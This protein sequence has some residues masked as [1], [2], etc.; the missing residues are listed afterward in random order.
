MGLMKRINT[1][2]RLLGKE[3]FQ[4]RPALERAI[5][6]GF[7]DRRH[8]EPVKQEVIGDLVVMLGEL[9]REPVHDGNYIVVDFLSK[10][11]ML[12]QL[13]QSNGDWFVYEIGSTQRKR[14]TDFNQRYYRWVRIHPL[15]KD[16][17]NELNRIYNSIPSA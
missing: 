9:V 5:I 11:Q 1:A 12:V 14:L 2:Y 7:W 8:D 6:Q 3:A 10:H 16:V 13:D 15:A 17:M 4:G